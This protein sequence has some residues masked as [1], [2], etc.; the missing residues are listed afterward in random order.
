MMLKPRLPDSSSAPRWLQKIQFV[1]NSIAYI[2]S[3]QRYGDI[4]NAP[5]V[6]NHDVVLFVSNP[7]A[8][9][10][11]FT[12]DTKQF[13][14]PPNQVLQPIV[15]DYSIFTLE[16]PRHR[17]ERRLLMPPFHGER[18]QTYGQLICELVD[19]AMSSL[20]IGTRFSARTLAQEIS[21]EVILKVVFGIDRE[22]CSDRL[23][24]LMT[25]FTD[26]LD[27]S[28][29]QQAS[30]YKALRTSFDIFVKTHKLGLEIV[31]DSL[32]LETYTPLIW[33]NSV[34]IT[35]N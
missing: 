6:G 10:R 27:L 5:V 23:K 8:L 19:K 17:R 26:S 34:I 12:S 7:Q 35:L 31:G 14:A 20:S 9:Q 24:S 18:M 30:P 15:G 4:F 25:N 22:D 11:I 3:A 2:D 16:D 29:N 13:V 28:E 21:L 32:A 1:R 33:L